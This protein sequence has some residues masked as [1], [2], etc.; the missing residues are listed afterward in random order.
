MTP[1]HNPAEG[2]PERYF[3]SIFIPARL[4]V[5]R[6]IGR[7]KETL[8]CALRDRLLHYKPNKASKIVNAC[9]VI[10]NICVENRL[11]LPHENGRRG[12]RFNP[13]IHAEPLHDRQG[14][15]GRVARNR[16]MNH[17]I[18]ERERRLAQQ[19]I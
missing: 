11:D 9:A 12:E 3:N 14:A 2:T 6:T 5:E 8:R 18:A 16:L 4:T 7:W 15:A 19:N 17:L 1:F 10:H 13:R